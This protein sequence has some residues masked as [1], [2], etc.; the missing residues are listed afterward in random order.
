ME[1]PERPLEVGQTLDVELKMAKTHLFDEETSQT[2][3]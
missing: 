3:I 1:A 2:I